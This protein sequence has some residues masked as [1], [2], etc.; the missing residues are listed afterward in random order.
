MNKKKC[1][2]HSLF[3][4]F[5]LMMAITLPVFAEVTD[6]QTNSKSF[7]KEGNITFNGQ[8]EPKSTGL[9][10]I[11]IR[12]SS[13]KFVMLTQAIT[14]ENY[15]FEKTIKINEQFT[16]HGIYSATGFILN[17]TAGVTTSFG[18][19]T[20]GIPVFIENDDLQISDPSVEEILLEKTQI[21]EPSIKD[22]Q[23]SEPP[24]KEI[25]VSEPPIRKIDFFDSSK[26]PQ[27]YLDRYYNEPTYKSWFDRNYPD[28]TIE[29]AVGYGNDVKHPKTTVE[30]FMEN[31]ILPEADATLLVQHTTQPRNNSENAQII[32]AV[33]GLG[34]LFGA[35]YG[36][37]RKVDN[38]SR[39]ISI[40]KDIIRKKII[41]PLL[42]SS[43][44]DILQTRLAKGEISL[45]EF[46]RLERKLG[47]KY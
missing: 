1:G 14:D 4:L 39:Q 30:Q 3:I 2:L 10:T 13:D 40:N 38:N 22:L 25:P 36:V 37:K 29:E 20:N 47:K 19:S 28:F 5:I 15:S 12:D 9:V 16:D 23:I 6:L 21:V 33:G 11:V 44:S 46:D 43:P 35:V 32:L 42:G 24:L 17:M 41:N 34:I 7:F 26:E 31:E 45:E 18:I 8:V 27:H